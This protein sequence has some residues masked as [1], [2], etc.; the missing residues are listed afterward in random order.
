MNHK[1]IAKQFHHWK[2]LTYP[3]VPLKAGDEQYKQLRFAF[4]G[5]SASLLVELL[6]LAGEQDHIG[7][8]ALNRYM[9]EISGFLATEKDNHQR[10][11]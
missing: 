11:K 10:K 5:G 2:D 1:T 3:G 4:F 8:E 9:A 6:A 7:V